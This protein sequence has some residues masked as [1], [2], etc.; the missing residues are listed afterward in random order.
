MTRTTL[1]PRVGLNSRQRRK[2]EALAYNY[3]RANMPPRRLWYTG[4][5]GSEYRSLCSVIE[6]RFKETGV[7]RL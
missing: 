1:K 7:I 2:I 3:L 4:I 6:K 5:R